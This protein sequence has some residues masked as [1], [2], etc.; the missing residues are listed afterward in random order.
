M[1]DFKLLGNY[2]N[3][4]NPSTT[5]LLDVPQVAAVTVDVFNVLGQR[6]HREEFQAVAAGASRPLPL[7]ASLL[8]SGAYMYQ[9]T[10]RMGKEVHRASGRMTLIK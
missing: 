4:F 5:I 8:S 9:V 1:V 2:P 10:A 6:V 7:D 3:P